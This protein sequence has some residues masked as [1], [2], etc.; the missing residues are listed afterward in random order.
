[1]SVGGEN[2][3][4]SHYYFRLGRSATKS[5]MPM[6]NWEKS[7]WNCC[8][9]TILSYSAQVESIRILRLK[10]PIKPK[11]IFNKLSKC[12]WLRRR[13]VLLL[14]FFFCSLLFFGSVL[15]GKTFISMSETS[16]LCI[17]C[18]KSQ[19]HM[20]HR[21]HGERCAFYL[22]WMYVVSAA[23]G[24]QEAGKGNLRIVSVSLHSDWNPSRSHI[25]FTFSA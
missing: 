3:S 4:L 7:K 14:I 6:I 12:R 10:H 15:C 8:M 21:A 16:V 23:A 19:N 13:S 11:H 9:S 25:D 20:T 22:K 17:T 5:K 18:H 1:M 2:Y 24:T